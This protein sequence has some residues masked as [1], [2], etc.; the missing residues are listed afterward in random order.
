MAVE[1]L[2]KGQRVE[3][4]KGKNL[5][6]VAVALGWDTNKYAGGFDFD[7]DVSVFMVTTDDRTGKEKTRDEGDFIFYNNLEH[8]SG[9]V[10]H[11][12]DELTGGTEGDDETIHVD[13][14]VMPAY[15]NK[16]AFV[17]TIYDAEK[18]RQAFGQVDNAYVRV[19]NQETNEEILRF[20]LGEDFSIETGV[21]V[22]EIY[23]V[24]GDWK[25]NA[26]GAGYADGLS[27]FVRQYGL[28]VA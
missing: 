8:A 4:T 23:K 11:T 7:L 28:E 13:F 10:R 6:K 18:R 26:I 27:G 20:D 21:A 9:A 5:S 1:L 24:A 12:G 3:L 15:I 17:V 22:C 19:Y 14:S 2:K 25:F 16:I